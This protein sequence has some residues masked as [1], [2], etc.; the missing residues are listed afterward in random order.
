MSKQDVSRKS[1]DSCPN[2]WKQRMK[3]EQSMPEGCCCCPQQGFLLLHNIWEPQYLV[4]AAAAL[5]KFFFF[6]A[7]CGDLSTYLSMLMQPWTST[8][9]SSQYVETSV[10]TCCLYAY[11]HLGQEGSSTSSSFWPVALMVPRLWPRAFSSVSP[12]LH[13]VVLGRP[14]L[15]LP[16]SLGALWVTV[17][18]MESPSFQS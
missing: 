7:S 4:K 3:Q 12:V 5:D 13:H 1:Q 17:L 2:R 15:L 10:L 18:V 9:S 16:P 14:L 11:W 6:F 8:F